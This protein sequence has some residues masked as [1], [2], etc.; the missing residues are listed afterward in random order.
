MVLSSR[1]PQEGSLAVSDL[2][3]WVLA[4]MVAAILCSFR[5]SRATPF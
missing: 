2:Q 5:M 1:L 4:R 3:V